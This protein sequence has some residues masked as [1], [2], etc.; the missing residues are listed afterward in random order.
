MTKAFTLNSMKGI[1]N[2]CFLMIAS[3]IILRP[4]LINSASVRNKSEELFSKGSLLRNKEKQPNRSL[5][6]FFDCTVPE[7]VFEIFD[8]IVDT[9]SQSIVENIEC[10][11]FEQNVDLVGNIPQVLPSLPRLNEL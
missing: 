5:Q 3:V 11:G 10:R 4:W 6:E 2:T 1:S 7:S 9:A 8:I